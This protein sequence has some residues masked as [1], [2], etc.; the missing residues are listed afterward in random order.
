[1]TIR[2]A[3]FDMD[4]TLLDSMYVWDTVGS[5]YL[6]SRGITPE[7]DCDER[8][9]DMSLSQAAHY[10]INRYRLSESPEDII[11][12]VNRQTEHFYRN[13]VKAKPGVQDFLVRLR[14]ENV[15]MCVATATVR[16]LAEAALQ[17]AGIAEFFSALL[18]CPEVGAGKDN[19]K[20]YEAACAKL[21]IR[22][23]EAIVFEDAPY[24]IQTAKGAGFKVA[25]VFD[26][27]SEAAWE[28]VVSLSDYSI[29]SYQEIK[30]EDICK[31][32][33]R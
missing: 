16:Y 14:E 15:K 8:L 2:A 27:S 1:M 26:R 29:R 24:A 23:E 17:K 31:K 9:R 3:I 19:P 20:I 12:G 13:D 28:T 11:A 4:G 22:K 18:T 6:R 7:D 10:I 25:C 30:W 33:L 21:D 32:F 5:E